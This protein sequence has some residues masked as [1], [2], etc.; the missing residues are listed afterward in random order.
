MYIGIATMRQCVWGV[1]IRVVDRILI[2]FNR[3]GGFVSFHSLYQAV[4]ASAPGTLMSW[5]PRAWKQKKMSWNR[6]WTV[7]AVGFCLFFLNWWILLLPISHFGQCHAVH[8]TM[9][10]VISACWWEDSGWADS[11]N[12]TSWRMSSIMR[13]RVSCRRPNSWRTS[14]PSICQHDSI[15]RRNGRGW[16]NVVNPFRATIVLGTPGSGKSFAVVNNYIKQQIEGYSMY[17]YDFQVFRPF[18]DCL[19]PHDEPS[20]WI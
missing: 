17:I 5:E 3:T 8:F 16:I 6:I 2:N 7:L 9:T 12:T 4:F 10:A 13:T 18:D 14:I 1:T 20:E 11:W 19:Q 15:T